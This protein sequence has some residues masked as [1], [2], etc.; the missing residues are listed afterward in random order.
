VT[1]KTVE[2]HLSNVY[3]KLDIGSRALLARRLSPATEPR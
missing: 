2:M 1:V 3:G